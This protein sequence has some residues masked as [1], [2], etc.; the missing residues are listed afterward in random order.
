MCARREES[1]VHSRKGD[2]LISVNKPFNSPE[3]GA[4]IDSDSLVFVQAIEVIDIV[5]KNPVPL[6]PLLY[7]MLP[8]PVT[9]RDGTLP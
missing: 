5:I 1:I 7:G 6:C 8:N 4:A 2:V 9:G 3:A